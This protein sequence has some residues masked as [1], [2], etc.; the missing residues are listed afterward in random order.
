M[1]PNG[2]WERWRGDIGRRVLDHEE[3]LRKL[4]DSKA[5]A[6]IDTARWREGVAARF[7]VL[8]T[9]IAGFAALGALAGG[10]V[11]ALIQHLLK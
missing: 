11:V 1:P 3:D 7:A 10:A 4:W 5:E 8:E 9:K 2:E 6:E